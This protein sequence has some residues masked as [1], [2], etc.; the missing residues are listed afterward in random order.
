MLAIIRLIALR[1]L[2]SARERTALTVCGIALGVA[3]VFAISVLNRSVLVAF[4]QAVENVSG[5]A[6][7]C[8]G[9]G[10]GLPEELLDRVRAVPGVAA[11]APIIE[12]TVRDDAHGV[13]LAL[14]G[15]D[16]AADSSVRD[17]QAF[18]DDV[19]VADDVA[20][21]NDPHGVLITRAYAARFGLR[22]GAELTL[23]SAQ[24]SSVYTVRGTLSP[25]GP[26]QVFGGDLVVMDIYAAQLALDRGRR[27]DRV[28]VVLKPGERS[29][30]VEE[31]ISLAL[32]HK[33]PLSRP[34][35]RTQDAERLL[36]SFKLA[37]SI[38][39]LVAIFVGAFIVYNSLS[40]AVAQRRREIGV[41][42]ALGMSRRLVRLLFVAEA[43]LMGALGSA[44][45]LGLGL[46]VARA[47]LSIV[48]E[49]VSA[50]YVKVKPQ[51][52]A[53]ESLD[54]WLAA[55]LGIAASLIAAWLPAQRASQ[56]DPVRALQKRQDA[57]DVSFGSLW[58]AALS[59]SVTLLL[60][61]S[62]A[63]LAHRF[64]ISWLG[65]VVSGLGA[66]GVAFMAP[67]VAAL[68]GRLGQVVLRR[69]GTSSR[70][71]SL[72]F[73]RDG[74]RSAIA[75]AALGTALANIILIDCLLGSVKSSTHSWL[76]RSF[77]ADIFVMA[78][79]SVRAKFDQ[80]MP[81]TMLPLLRADPDVTFVQPFRMLQQSYQGTPFYLM[82]EDLR[83]Y[84]D[85]NELAV[86]DGD[87]RAAVGAMRRGESVGV[88]QTFA[89][90][91]GKRV[92]DVL[93]LDTVEGPRNFRVDLI[94]V[95]YRTDAGAVL[96]ER[97]VFTRAFADTRVDLYGVYL[98]KGAQPGAARARI[99][100]GVAQRQR[101]LV[102]DNRNYMQ[103]L[104]GL[105][106]RSL[107]LSHA[108][109]AVAVLVAVLGMFNALA[110]SVLDRKSEYGALRAI[111]ASRGQL[112]RVVL[113]EALLMAFSASVLGVLMGVLLSAYSVRESLRFQLGWQLDLSLSTRVI[114]GVF[115]LAQ[116][117]GA[118]SAWLP[119]RNA[120]GTETGRALAA[121]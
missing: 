89:R 92:G 117:V 14:L 112:Q 49:T 33:V 70:L 102:L 121:E 27:F 120:A 81:E 44:L 68:V 84:L 38:T 106:D 37:L 45:G 53:V 2:K 119:M 6:A 47:A 113:T 114:L 76:A 52:L 74:G 1:G 77:R 30:S 42:R 103:E 11:A 18:A 31:R 86:A 109:E 91:F 56:V 17:Y 20:F 41:L 59:S 16:T 78:G 24:G 75:I 29:D 39:S 8:V 100:A 32:E 85:Y 79:T 63:W 25:T 36:A 46:G 82:A 64:E 115:L 83:G 13:T 34:E 88:S 9:R 15:V 5:K 61:A 7:L 73:R 95:D 118:L 12:D 105:I 67:V 110:V 108:G 35:Q 4:R 54:L 57:A 40:I 80:P 3:V 28:D 21:L 51:Q 116:L 90:Q 97:A 111:G 71:G 65:H 66:L 94:Y 104:L 60:A 58:T 96:I 99:S 107:A 62:C 69:A 87:F 43:A 10:T 48:G 98:K 26:A 50:L 72:S 93:Q 55:A 23:S 19:E 22:V 101:L